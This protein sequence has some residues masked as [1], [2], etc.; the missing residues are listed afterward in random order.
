MNAFDASIQTYI[1]LAAP[2]SPLFAHAVTDIAGFAFFK[3]LA[4]LAVMC[5]MWFKP[6]QSLEHRREMVIA[7]LF[8]A[9]VAFV[10]GRLLAA[11]LPFRPR[12]VDAVA[13]HATFPVAS[14][15]DDH[16]RLWS[17]FPSDHA[18]LWMAVAVGIFLVRRWIGALA[19]LHCVVFICLPRVYLGFH[20]PTDVIAGAII[21]AAVVVLAT[22]APL[23]TRFAPPVMRYIERR[24]AVG[25]TLAFLFFFE[26]ATMFDEPRLLAMALLRVL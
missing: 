3:G 23:R 14:R 20:Y 5:A 9:F 12:P 8:A 15:P 16:R 11:F 25:Y 18:A 19:I 2:S 13:L 17:S 4:P 6:G 1:A 21:G 24:P 7:I 10:A 26:L 22:R